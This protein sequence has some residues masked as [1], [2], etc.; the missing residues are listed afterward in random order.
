MLITAGLFT[1]IGQFSGE[2]LVDVSFLKNFEI[3]N[4]FQNALTL[5]GDQTFLY[6]IITVRILKLTAVTSSFS[7]SSF[8]LNIYNRMNCE[9]ECS[10][11]TY[12]AIGNFKVLFL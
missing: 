11:L 2:T 12:K 7:N 4:V 5:H 8:Q 10:W 6:K 3:F 9:K 1:S